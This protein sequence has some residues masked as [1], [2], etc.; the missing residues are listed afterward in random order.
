VREYAEA[1]NVDLE[2][3]NFGEEVEYLEQHYSAADGVF[4]LAEGGEA[5]PARRSML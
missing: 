2:F 3:Q 4:L 1:L 5:G